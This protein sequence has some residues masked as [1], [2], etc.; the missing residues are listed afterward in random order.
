[1][2]RRKEIEKDFK[3]L[4]EYGRDGKVLLEVLLDIRDL[5]KQIK[6]KKGAR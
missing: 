6:P 1:M 5:L 3:G 4:V 2:R